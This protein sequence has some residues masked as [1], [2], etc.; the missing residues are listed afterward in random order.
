MAYDPNLASPAAP[1]I[2]GKPSSGDPEILKSRA[3]RA[4]LFHYYSYPVYQNQGTLKARAFLLTQDL[5]HLRALLAL[6]EFR[7]YQITLDELEQ[8]TQ[9]HFP[10]PVKEAGQ[11]TAVRE[12]AERK[13]LA[14]LADIEW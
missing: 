7:V 3:K 13:P 12:I 8:R 2:P 10:E 9:L 14:A 11:L 6:D 1:R 5:D 4:I